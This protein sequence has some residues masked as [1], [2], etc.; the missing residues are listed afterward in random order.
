MSLRHRHNPRAF[1]LP[2]VLASL[3]L[4]G[5]VLP[6]VMKGVSLALQASDDARKRTEAVGL[7]ETKLSEI[8]ASVTTGGANSTTAG[9]FGA[10]HPN[11]RWDASIAAAAGA[12][13]SLSEVHVRVTWRGRG[14]ERSVDLSTFTYAGTSSGSLGN[15][16]SGTSGGTP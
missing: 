12:S 7:A 5:L 15:I 6:A 1:T 11:F 2:E 9:D 10:E 14:T 16:T 3:V 8:S 13:S 4:V